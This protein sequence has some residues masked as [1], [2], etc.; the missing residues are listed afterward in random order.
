MPKVM[1]IIVTKL[2]I[3]ATGATTNRMNPLPASFQKLE[4]ASLT[5]DFT[6][7]LARYSAAKDATTNI[8]V[9]TSKARV[10]SPKINPRACFLAGISVLW[11]FA[12]P[13]I[14]APCSIIA[15]YGAGHHVY[16]PSHGN[17]FAAGGISNIDVSSRR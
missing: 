5:T 8:I 4:D 12:A 3:I 7:V 10:R 17:Q 2:M 11:K 14:V 6:W 13:R 15:S 9:F 1:P 16:L